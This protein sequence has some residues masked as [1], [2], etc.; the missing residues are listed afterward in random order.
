VHFNP[1]GGL[2]AE[3]AAALVNAGASASVDDLRRALA[4]HLVLDA[5]LTPEQAAKLRVWAERLRPVFGDGLLVERVRLVNELLA[6]SA[7]RPYVSCHDRRPPHLHF[8]HEDDGVVRRVTAFTAAGVAMAVCEDP[9]R[10]G[11]CARVGCSVVFVDTSRNGRRRFCTTRCANRVYV[12][13]HR[14]RSQT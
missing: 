7:S 1:Y 14:S 6:D 5:V 4:R 10:L 13:D 9:D 12:A 3:L 11:T 2:A 8:A